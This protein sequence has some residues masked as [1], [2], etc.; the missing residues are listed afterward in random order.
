MR[1]R[2]GFSAEEV[3]EF[4]EMFNHYDRDGSGELSFG[5]C[6]SIL[7]DLGKEPETLE[8]QDQLLRRMQGADKD[9]SECLNLHE[10]LFLMRR[11]MDEEECKRFAKESNAARQANFSE[12]EV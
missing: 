8:Q 7:V 1:M 6:T 12:A 10:F 3:L 4:Q 9:G 11:F 2:S 5:E